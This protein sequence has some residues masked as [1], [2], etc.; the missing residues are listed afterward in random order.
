MG[1][2]RGMDVRAARSLLAVSLGA[3]ALTACAAPKPKLSHRLP[4]AGASPGG[5][6]ATGAGGSTLLRGRWSAARSDCSA[7]PGRSCLHQTSRS[8]PTPHSQRATA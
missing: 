6:A 2:V 7:T 4:D 8:I 1:L 5:R 3:L